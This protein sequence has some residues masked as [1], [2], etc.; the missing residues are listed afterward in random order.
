MQMKTDPKI[1]RAKRWDETV[2]SPMWPDGACISWSSLS[3]PFD[4]MIICETNLPLF[5]ISVCYCVLAWN[6][7]KVTAARSQ[8]SR[9]TSRD[10]I[11]KQRGI[12]QAEIQAWAKNENKIKRVQKKQKNV[13][14]LKKHKDGWTD[15]WINREI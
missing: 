7:L 9:P 5:F 14:K 2:R 8:F 4:Q 6:M 1:A 10:V 11:G 15:R 12:N 13:C 3:D